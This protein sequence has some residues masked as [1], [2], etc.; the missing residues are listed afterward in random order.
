[1]LVTGESTGGFGAVLN[2]DRIAE[3]FTNMPVTLL[4]DSWP[5]LSDTYIH[6]CMQQQWRELWGF[7]ETLPE[8]C[9]DCFGPDGGGI[10]QLAPDLA[11][12]HSNQKM[13]LI[14]ST[15]DDITRLFLGFG[16]TEPD[17]APC[18]GGLLPTPMEQWFFEFGLYELRDTILD[19]SPVWGRYLIDSTAHTWI[20]GDSLFSTEVD[21][22]ML[23][24]WFTE[25][26]D[27]QVAHV[28]P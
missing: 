2:Y 3:A 24:D 16:I 6:A 10:F 9:T 22:V 1:M 4:D 18:N 8:A 19:G 20:S 7:D 25:L 21:G 28:G 5:P 17:D 27:G 11:N 14:S 26:V 12:K 13:A 23:H 15:G